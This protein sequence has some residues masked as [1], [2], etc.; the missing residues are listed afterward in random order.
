MQ[1]KHILYDQP[2]TFTLLQ[3]L[4][5]VKYCKEDNAFY[6]EYKVKKKNLVRDKLNQMTNA[7]L[8]FLTLS[9]RRRLSYR[10]Q[11][12]CKSMNWFLYD[13]DF[14]HERVNL[15]KKVK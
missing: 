5:H 4:Y 13:R 2:I 14:R 1:I 10:N 12:L 9:R 11:L 6:R 7:F 15:N 3:S 8:C